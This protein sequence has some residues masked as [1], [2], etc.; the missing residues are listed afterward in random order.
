VPQFLIRKTKKREKGKRGTDAILIGTE[1]V[2]MDSPLGKGVYFSHKRPRRIYRHKLF[3]RFNL[4]HIND[5]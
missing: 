4:C 5:L 1:F 2:M 3:K